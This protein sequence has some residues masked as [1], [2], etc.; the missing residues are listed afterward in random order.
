M[1]VVK[2]AVEE[3]PTT[4][5]PLK[6]EMGGAFVQRVSAHK[7]EGVKFVEL[8]LVLVVTPSKVREISANLSCL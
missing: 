2:P 1:A 3:V 7:R 6:K 8:T 4:L 5:R